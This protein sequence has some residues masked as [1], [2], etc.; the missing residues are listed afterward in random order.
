MGQPTPTLARSTKQE[1]SRELAIPLLA[2]SPRAEIFFTIRG[3][4]HRWPWA[5]HQGIAGRWVGAVALSVPAAKF[6][7]LDKKV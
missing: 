1:H 5:R 3:H 7:V 2:T 4:C 6:A